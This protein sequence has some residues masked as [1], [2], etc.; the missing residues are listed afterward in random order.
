MQAIKDKF[1]DM[2]AMR[3]AK[4]EAKEEEK[5]E[6]DLAK[7]RVEVAHEVRLAKEAEAAM[8]LHVNRAAEKIANEEGKYVHEPAEG[9]LDPYA[10]SFTNTQLNNA[11]TGPNNNLL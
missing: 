1:K 3:K 2:S 11:G 6:K 9:T 10:S 5:A 7:T 8:H 4:A